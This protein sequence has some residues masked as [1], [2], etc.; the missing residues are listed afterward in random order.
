LGSIHFVNS[1]VINM[2]PGVRVATVDL[3]SRILS[4]ASLVVALGSVAFLYMQSRVVGTRDE[5]VKQ[6]NTEL[7]EQARA[8]DVARTNMEAK[9]QTALDNDNTR[10]EGWNTQLNDALSAFRTDATSLLAQIEANEKTASEQRQQAFRTALE[11][12]DERLA[13][14]STES[15]SDLNGPTN[16]A[17]AADTVP[18]LKGSGA[19]TPQAEMASLRLANTV[20]KPGTGNT[21]LMVIQ[22]GSDQDALIERIRFRPVSVFQTTDS[23]DLAPDASSTSVTTVSYDLT[24]NT[25]KQAGHHGIYDRMLTDKIRVPAGESVTL[26]VVINDKQN[27]GWGFTGKLVL[28]YD[29]KEPLTVESARIAFRGES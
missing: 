10:M 19:T 11:T 23:L 29:G 4:V 3:T 13:G 25:S 14:N 5:L 1:K 20:L 12:Y 15:A 18:E 22:N 16:Q 21:T 2:E 24:D 7:T 17:D 26:R 27:E 6:F 28:D 8:F 9:L